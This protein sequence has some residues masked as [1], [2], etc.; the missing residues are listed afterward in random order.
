MSRFTPSWSNTERVSEA[1]VRSKAYLPSGMASQID[2]L[3][4]PA[5]LA[6]LVTTLGVWAGSHFFGVGEIVDVGLLLV[7][8][9]FVGWSITDVAEDLFIFGNKSINAGRDEDIDIAAKAFAAAVVTAGIT[10]VMALLLRRS[11]TQLQVT[12]GANVSQIIRPQN[13]GLLQAGS[14]SQAGRFWRKPAVTGDPTLP[15]GEGETNAFGDVR[16]STAGSATEQQLVRIHELVHSFFSPR[17]SVLRTFRARL[18]MSA[19]SRS[20]IL[21]YLEEGLA[22]SVAQVSAYGVAGLLRGIRFPIANGY[23]TLQ[24]LSSE[25]IEIGTIVV[26][27]QRFSVQIVV[28]PPPPVCTATDR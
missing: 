26:G 10:A 16:Y 12:R 2:A 17:L 13:P 25:G 11:A 1:L 22:E 28:S 3:L 27:A 24:Q 23:I 8:A 21:C 19:Y 4:S 7:G 5:T 14:D 9:F 6:I 15:A 18:A 20:A